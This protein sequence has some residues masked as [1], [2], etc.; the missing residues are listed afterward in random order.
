MTIEV[1]K[2]LPNGKKLTKE[3]NLN[4]FRSN[5]QCDGNGITLFQK[6]KKMLFLTHIG[7]FN[8]FKENYEKL[9]EKAY[10]YLYIKNEDFNKTL[11]NFE[12][13]YI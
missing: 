4:T 10:H 3:L 8:L 11:L 13:E 7:I 2:F 6:N 5:I 9:P 1:Y 12:V